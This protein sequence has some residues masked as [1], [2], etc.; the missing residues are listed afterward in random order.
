LHAWYINL[1]RRTDRRAA[2]E[3]QLARLGLAGERIEAILAA[4]LPE[5]LKQRYLP[6]GRHERLSVQEFCC[7]VSHLHACRALLASGEPFGL[8]LEDD[9]VL[10]PRLPD[11]LQQFE[12]NP[13]GIDLLRLETFAA[14]AQISTQAQ[15]G[16]GGFA[17]HTMHGWA[18]G[19]A[20]YIISARAAKRMVDNPQALEEVIDRVIYRPHRSIL[21]R[22]KRRQLVPALAIQEDRT[23]GHE[24]GAGSDMAPVRAAMRAAA[25]QPFAKR[26]ASFIDNELLVALPSSLHRRLGRSHKVDIPYLGD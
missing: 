17:F 9:I 22:V 4:D 24:W 5:T 6:G 25:R 14:P 18:W 26:L 11:F 13:Q 2:M 20:A 12:A 10:S 15:G 8:I 21:G 23:Q 19:A 16:I 1:A 7:G 3:A